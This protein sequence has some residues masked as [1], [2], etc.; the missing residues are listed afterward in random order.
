MIGTGALELPSVTLCAVTS[1]NVGATIAAMER[2]LAQ[3]RFADAML[4]TDVAIVPTN[5]AIRVV[6]IDRLKSIGD[7]SRFVLVELAAHIASEHC[8][9]VQWDGFVLDAAVWDQRFL[10]FDYIGAP[11]PQFNDGWDVGNGGFSLRSRRLMECC[12]RMPLIDGR[13]E[14]LVICRDNRRA[15]EA[16]GMRFASRELAARFA[17]ERDR[18]GRRTFGFHGVF[19]MVDVVGAD[20]FWN[21]YCRLDNRSTVYLDEAAITIAL[22]QGCNAVWRRSKLRIDALQFRLKKRLQILLGWLVN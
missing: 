2:C 22:Q 11:W 16:Q 9:V 3:I 4:F 21:I 20:A 1:V 19:N 8:L 10:E 14:D 18:T 5:P 15:L 12:G 17:Y 13:S 7:Y 6:P